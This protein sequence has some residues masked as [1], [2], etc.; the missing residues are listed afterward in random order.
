TAFRT[1][2]SEMDPAS[3]GTL[4]S[5]SVLE[6]L[7][8]LQGRAPARRP[9]TAPAAAEP[10]KTPLMGGIDPTPTRPKSE[11]VPHMD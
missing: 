9:A 6:W 3:A 1:R 2:S 11:S 10:V 7:G 4:F 8:R 5:L